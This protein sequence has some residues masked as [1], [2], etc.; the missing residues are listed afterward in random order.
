MVKENHML[1]HITDQNS[2]FRK[3]KMAAADILKLF[4]SM[5]KPLIIR[6]R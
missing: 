6:C 3:I 1:K 2:K 5:S 4:L